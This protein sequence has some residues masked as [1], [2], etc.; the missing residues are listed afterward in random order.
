[1]LFP[2]KELLRRAMRR[3]TQI[4]CT[5]L[6]LVTLLVE[7]DIMDGQQNTNGAAHS[8]GNQVRPA[9]GAVVPAKEPALEPTAVANATEP[10]NATKEATATT[11]RG[12]GAT[13]TPPWVHNKSHDYHSLS[14]SVILNN[15]DKKVQQKPY[16]LRSLLSRSCD[17]LTTP[18]C[19]SAPGGPGY[20]NCGFSSSPGM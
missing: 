19:G 9:T 14:G 2:Q 20:P 3:I 12:P 13:P 15:N 1:V 17:V 18:Y 16:F 7:G 5:T 4:A 8:G 6:L 11:E 10:A